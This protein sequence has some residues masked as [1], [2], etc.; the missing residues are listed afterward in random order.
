MKIKLY[1]FITVIFSLALSF[2]FISE[3]HAVRR[4]ASQKKP[5]APVRLYILDGGTLENAD[6]KRYQLDSSE[7]AINRFSVTCYLIVHP[8]GTLIWDTGTVPDSAWTY[9][10]SPT[11]YN[12][13]Q[14]GFKRLITLVKPIKLQ[15]S[16]IGY[17]PAEIKYIALSHY[18][19]DHSANAN[20]FKNSIWLVRQNERDSMFSNHTPPVTIPSTYAGLRNNKTQIITTDEYDVFGDGSVIIKSAPG[21]S[22]GHQ[23]L[24]VR[25]KKTGNILIG[26]DLY[27]YPEERKLDRVPVFDFNQQQDRASRKIIEAFIKEKNAQLWI[28][29]DFAAN[30]RLKKAPGYYE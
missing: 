29:H 17:S 9:N 18:H 8:K 28:Q 5:D 10:G 16:E 23:V 2:S 25:L 1:T 30:A 6:P 3:N 13:V 22:P 26:G 7:V 20:E 4:L 12:L 21:H 15:L 11:S 19:Y 27:H 24:F 14:P